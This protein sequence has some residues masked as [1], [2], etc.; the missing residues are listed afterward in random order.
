MYNTLTRTASLVKVLKQGS[1]VINLMQI[2]FLHLGVNKQS[3]PDMLSKFLQLTVLAAEE[4]LD[5]HADY[6]NQVEEHVLSGAK[7]DLK[8][9]AYLKAGLIWIAVSFE[10]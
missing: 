1:V 2:L 7:P 5:L 10:I 9:F 8:G 6:L 4:W 3:L